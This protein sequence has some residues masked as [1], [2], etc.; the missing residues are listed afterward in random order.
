M[1]NNSITVTSDGIELELADGRTV[2]PVLEDTVHEQK[3]ITTQLWDAD[4]YA[5]YAPHT[6]AE[7]VLLWFEDVDK[8]IDRQGGD[9]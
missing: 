1:N 4:E 5:K 7:G 6:D 3:L 2:R 8:E 9:S